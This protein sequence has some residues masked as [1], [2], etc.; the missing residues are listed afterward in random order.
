MQNPTLSAAAVCIVTRAMYRHGQ[1][2]VIRI[3]K[4][5]LLRVNLGKLGTYKLQVTYGVISLKNEE[6]LSVLEKKMNS[7][8][9]LAK[10]VYDTDGQNIYSL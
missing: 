2:I 8:Y 9:R 7:K 5:K 1:K 3:K 10:G 6:I 4:L